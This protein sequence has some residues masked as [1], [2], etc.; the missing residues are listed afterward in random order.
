MEKIRIHMVFFLGFRAKKSTATPGSGG[1][2][3]NQSSRD[4]RKTSTLVDE[5]IEKKHGELAGV[6]KTAYAL[7]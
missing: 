2:W 1:G 5:E 7:W 3:A 6:F 4:L